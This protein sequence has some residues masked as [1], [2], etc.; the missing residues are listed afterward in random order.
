MATLSLNL[1]LGYTGQA[2]LAHAGFFGI[3]AYGVAMITKAGY[4]FWLALPIA[5]LI[6]AFIGL[7]I[8]MLTL[9]TRG[10]YFAISTL[11][12]GV[13]VF[14][15][16]GSWIDFT[17]GYT[18]LLGIPRPTPIPVPFLGDITFVSQVSQYYLVIGFL[19]LTLFV[20]YRIVY[21]S[22][23]LS[24]MAVRNNEVL[25]E[26]V[27]I[28]TFATKLLSFITAD[29]MVAVAGGIYAA[30]MGS[31]SPTSASFN[32]TFFWLAYL[33]IGGIATLAGPIIGAFAV[34]FLVEYMYAL[35]EY[36]L[37]LFGLVLIL[38]IIFF[39]RGIMGIVEGI[40]V[41]IQDYYS[42]RGVGVEDVAENRKIDETL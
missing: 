8:G 3:G 21:S 24:F 22:Q 33:I 5:A 31:I 39:P 29:F 20:K 15:V 26:A 6:S 23:G 32:L 41:K 18:G 4:S 9:R 27:G 19:L 1:I 14:V 11:C 16:S 42:R 37:M 36:R 25:A 12:F 7:L 30:L 28:N 10:H 38:A 2:S 40:R 35:G 34:S 13:I 17:G